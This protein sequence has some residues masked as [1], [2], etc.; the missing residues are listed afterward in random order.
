[1]EPLWSGLLITTSKSKCRDTFCFG[2]V[3]WKKKKK[4]S[5]LRCGFR[6]QIQWVDDKKRLLRMDALELLEA[7]AICLCYLELQS[8]HLANGLRAQGTPGLQWDHS[9]HSPGATELRRRQWWCSEWHRST[10][11]CT[12]WVPLC[13]AQNRFILTGH[14][15]MAVSTITFFLTITFSSLHIC[16]YICFSLQD[17]HR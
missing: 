7:I 8:L 9:T 4:R 3:S 2:H 13:T 14:K 1:M 16:S 15:L 11:N 12:C 10:W 5:N 6:W 17:C